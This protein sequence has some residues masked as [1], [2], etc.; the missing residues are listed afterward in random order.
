[1]AT[2]KEAHGA[3]AAHA[4]SKQPGGDQR[5]RKEERLK[6]RSEFLRTQRS[7]SIRKTSAHL[8]MYARPNDVQ[9]SRIGLT[10]SKKV[11]HAATRNL[12]K[13]RLREIFRLNKGRFPGDHDLVLIVRAQGPP[14]AYGALEGEVLS[15]ARRVIADSAAGK[16]GSSDGR[17]PG[18]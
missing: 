15:L 8:V 14:P 12:W 9:W 16:R 10:V 13:R 4:A 11:G 17:K 1:M 3:D 7:G 2:S 6:K 18:A 5:L